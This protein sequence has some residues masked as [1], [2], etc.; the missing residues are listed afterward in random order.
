MK[1]NEQKSYPKVLDPSCGKGEFL[2]ESAK[3]M[4]AKGCRDV[5][6]R[7]YA[8][9]F[10]QLN[11]LVTKKRLENWAKNNN[12]D[13][14]EFRNRIQYN[15]VEDL[16]EKIGTM[17]FD[18]VVGNPPYLKG[19]W[20]KFLKESVKMS[21]GHV[22]LVSPDATKNFSSKTDALIEFLKQNGVQHIR[23]CTRHFPKVKSGTIAVYHLEAGKKYNP[24]CFEAGNIDQQIVA[25]IKD[26]AG[27][28]LEAK[29]SSKRS[30]DMYSGPRYEKGG[31]GR[32]QTV[33]SVVKSG[34]VY[35]W[36]D[37]GNVDVIT[38]DDYWLMNRYFGKDADITMVEHS[39]KIGI[40]TNIMAIKRVPGMSIVDFK[41]IYLSPL[42]RT[43]LNSMRNGAFDTKPQHI[44]LLPIVDKTVKDLYQYF[45]LTP[46]E[47]AHVENS[48]KFNK[49]K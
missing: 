24:S 21:T 38:G 22:A 31:E 29:L 43:A 26:I 16:V 11:L 48:I 39:G 23:D 6:D 32:I 34:P 28:K 27:P 42:F 35:S 7:L 13:Q 10:K 19:M 15:R 40:S 49:I 12:Q 18:I 46:E 44:R 36:I 20:V 1:T 41:S 47:I 3:K 4:S 25:K 8:A 30:K 5:L 2:L 9:D 14:L 33:E 37:I 17:K 45:G